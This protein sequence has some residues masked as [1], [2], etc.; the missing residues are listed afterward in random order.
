MLDDFVICWLGFGCVGWCLWC[1][2]SLVVM[3]ADLVGCLIG[4]LGFGFCG[5][6]LRWF[7]VW[8]VWVDVG[9]F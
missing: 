7:L 9:G 6:V 2:V 4:N 5:W 8:W 3:F 1:I